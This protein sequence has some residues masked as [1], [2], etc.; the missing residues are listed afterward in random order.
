MVTTAQSPSDE[1]GKERRA[2]GLLLFLASSSILPE[3][4][5]LN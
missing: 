1:S 5:Y 2:N 3:V 4:K